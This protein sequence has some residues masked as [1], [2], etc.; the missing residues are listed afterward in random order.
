[1]KT[2]KNKFIIILALVLALTM[3]VFVFT[4]CDDEDEDT[5]TYDYYTFEYSSELNGAVL[6]S[7]NV[8]SLPSDADVPETATITDGDSSNE[9]SVVAIGDYAFSGATSLSTISLPSSVITIG[10]YAFNGCVALTSVDIS[11]VAEIG[12]YA[13]KNNKKLT[14]VT[15]SSTLTEISDGAFYGNMAL[16]EVTGDAKIATIGEKAFHSCVTMIKLN[17]DTSAVTTIG[18][19]AFFYV[20][21]TEFTVAS[22]VD[23]VGASAFAGWNESQT[24]YYYSDNGFDDSW[25]DGV[26]SSDVFERI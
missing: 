7:V 13:F 24:V 12:E 6:T 10:D 15:L 18:A 16:I 23:Y 21:L 14:S 3:S 5:D 1:M 4:A 8:N 25:K 22:S 11:N 17:V 2:L 20:S 9:Y 26:V 19:Q